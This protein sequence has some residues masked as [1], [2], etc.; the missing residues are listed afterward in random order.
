M[1]VMEG[2]EGMESDGKERD[3]KEKEWKVIGEECMEGD[4]RKGRNG[5]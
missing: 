2:K 1:E 4:G 3:G 5:K